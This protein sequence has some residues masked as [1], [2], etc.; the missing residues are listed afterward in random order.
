MIPDWLGEGD[1]T[2]PQGERRV[3]CMVMSRVV[4]Y[5]TPVSNWHRSK[6]QEFHDRVTFDRAVRETE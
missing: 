6:Q 4:G 3:P 1:V 2:E 5:L